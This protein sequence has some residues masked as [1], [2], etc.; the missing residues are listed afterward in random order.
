MLLYTY[1]DIVGKDKGNKRL[2]QQVKII[3]A[4]NRFSIM[5]QTDAIAINHILINICWEKPPNEDHSKQP[6]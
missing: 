2:A 4:I 1:T 5:H 3:W 6:L